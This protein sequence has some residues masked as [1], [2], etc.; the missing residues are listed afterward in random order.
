MQ[1]RRH[2]EILICIY[3]FLFTLIPLLDIYLYDFCSWDKGCILLREGG[4]NS[5]NYIHNL[6]INVVVHCIDIYAEHRV[7]SIYDFFFNSIVFILR[8]FYFCVLIQFFTAWH[9]LLLTMQL[10]WFIWTLCYDDLFVRIFPSL[11][12]AENLSH[13]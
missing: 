13:P 9:I 3:R 11:S 12:A 1:W 4:V 6:I 10:L 5:E 8:Y 7:K 2:Y